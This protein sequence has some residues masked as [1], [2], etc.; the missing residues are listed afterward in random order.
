MIAFKTSRLKEN[1]SN[2]QWPEQYTNTILA[3]G[4]AGTDLNHR[5]LRILDFGGGCGV[6]Y[7]TAHWSFVAPFRWAIVESTAMAQ[8]ARAMGTGQFEAFDNIHAGAAWLGQVDLVYIS[9]TIQYV[10]DP[11]GSL[12]AMISLGAPYFA[13]TRFPI[14][15]KPPIVGVQSTTLAENGI[16]PVPPDVV[17]RPI[18]YPVTFLN[19]E[20]VKARI[21]RVYRP[22]FSLP[23]ASAE[24]QV[25][26]ENVRGV[27][28][29]FRRVF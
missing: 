29:I 17:D 18:K 26:G 19:I 23:S 22:V 20:D 24:Y 25:L 5:P 28:A 21:N 15:T 27:T 12:D 3:V 8:Q 9:G 7:F 1:T 10:P 16:G 2:E 13:L 14:W 11:M 4:L 6:H